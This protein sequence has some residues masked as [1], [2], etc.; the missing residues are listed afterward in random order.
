M[1]KSYLSLKALGSYV[2]DLIARLK[3]LQEWYD[4]GVPPMFLVS[5]FFFTQAFLTGSKQNY[6]RKYTIPI[7]LLTFVFE[8]LGDN[9]YETPPEDGVYVN[10]LFMESC[11]WDREERVIRESHPKALYDSMPVLWLKLCKKEEIVDRS[12]YVA[13]VYKTSE[14]RGTLSTTGHST[15]FV[16][17]MRLPSD[18]PQSHWIMRGVALLCQLDD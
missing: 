8:V 9:N 7:D 11:R 10:G 18:Q 12:R 5:G 15:N 13:P 4:N 1:E 16:M 14:R 6:A 17:D 2:N 3:F